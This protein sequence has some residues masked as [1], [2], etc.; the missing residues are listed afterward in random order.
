MTV[1]CTDSPIG[2]ARN[3]Y[4]YTI[5]ER[6]IRAEAGRLKRLHAQAINVSGLSYDDLARQVLVRDQINIASSLGIQNFFAPWSYD[7]LSGNVEIE[8]D[9]GSAADMILF[10]LRVG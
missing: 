10:K 3:R 7:G 4:L 8:F 6:E 2:G 1:H 9:F 5:P